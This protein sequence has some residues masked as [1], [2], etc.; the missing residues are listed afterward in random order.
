VDFSDSISTH[1][2]SN[3]ISNTLFAHERPL[4]ANS[5]RSKT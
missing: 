3:T 5:G 2:L 1:S 4:R